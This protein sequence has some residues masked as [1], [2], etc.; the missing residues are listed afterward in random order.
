MASNKIEQ[1]RNPYNEAIKKLHR[2]AIISSRE[3]LIKL[4][5]DYCKSNFSQWFLDSPRYKDV[6]IEVVNSLEKA[7]TRSQ[8]LSVIKGL[9]E[10]ISAEEAPFRLNLKEDFADL[11]VVF[12]RHYPDHFDPTGL[13]FYSNPPLIQSESDSINRS[14]LVKCWLRSR[15]LKQ[16]D[17]RK[18]IDQLV[19]VQDEDNHELIIY[20]LQGLQ[21]VAAQIPADRIEVILQ[22]LFSVYQTTDLELCKAAN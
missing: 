12:F 15:R 6:A 14:E 17:L 3:I 4:L 5:R 1:K 22:R 21:A 16:D 9:D 8:V 18:D 13:K 10:K 20:L 11:W 7:K 19:Q 2:G